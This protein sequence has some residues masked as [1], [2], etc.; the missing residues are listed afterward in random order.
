LTRFAD[1]LVVF[2]SAPQ[3]TEQARDL[4]QATPVRSGLHS[5]PGITGI[6]KIREGKEGFDPLE[7][8]QR[9]VSS[10]NQRGPYWLNKWPSART[11]A[12]AD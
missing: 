10:L 9:V 11:F 1:N 8:R 7:F 3:R 12:L 6:A 2:R 4:A 5:Y